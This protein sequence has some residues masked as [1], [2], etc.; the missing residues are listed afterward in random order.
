MRE[1]LGILGGAF[2]PPHV[3][4]LILGEFARQQLDLDRVLYMPTGQPPHKQDQPVTAAE[5]RLAMTK[6]AIAGNDAFAVSTADIERPAP[7]YTV[8]LLPSLKK[9]FSQA[10]FVLVIGGDSLRD[11]PAWRQP[12]VI[13]QQWEL[14]VLPRPD[15]H[16]DWDVLEAAAPGVRQATTLLDGPFVALS[17]TQIRRWVR[18]GRS[19]RYLMPEAIAQYIRQHALYIDGARP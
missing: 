13:V 14:A 3:G 2:D 8:T 4:H 7:H 9:R 6:L 5:H 12:Q 18:D 16:V 10:D 15:S 1:R 19:M 11:L 17:S